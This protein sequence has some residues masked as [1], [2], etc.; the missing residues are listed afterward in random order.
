MR[1]EIG[2]S[3]V[4]IVLSQA[5]TATASTADFKSALLMQILFSE[6]CIT[7]LDQQV[8]TLRGDDSD[9]ML[10]ALNNHKKKCSHKP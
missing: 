2:G 4:E 1:W 5:K 9:W 10:P 6:T 3:R 7:S 8:C